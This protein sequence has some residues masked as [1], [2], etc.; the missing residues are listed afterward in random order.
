MQTA[1]KRNKGKRQE[2]R[3]TNTKEKAQKTK[4]GDQEWK[5]NNSIIDS[6]A[7]LVTLVAGLQLEFVLLEPRVEWG[8]NLKN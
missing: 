8:Q 7:A 1:R 4:R 6:C 2:R 5:T 3:K